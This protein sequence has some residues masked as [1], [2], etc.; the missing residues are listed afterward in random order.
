MGII[1]DP[2]P[3]ISDFVIMAISMGFPLIIS[4]TASGLLLVRYRRLKKERGQH[5][6]NGHDITLQLKIHQPQPNIYTLF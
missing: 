6:V 2:D 1:A 5:F 4:M 3:D